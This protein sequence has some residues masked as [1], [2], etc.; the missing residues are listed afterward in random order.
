MEANTANIIMNQIVIDDDNDVTLFCSY[1]VNGLWMDFYLSLHL[2]SLDKL[3]MGRG[4]G[5]M[6]LIEVISEEYIFSDVNPI[7][8]DVREELGLPL[9][10]DVPVD[11]IWHNKEADVYFYE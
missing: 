8:I 11:K 7:L 4:E 5:G 3:L 2:K 1:N 10:F 9:M 6:R